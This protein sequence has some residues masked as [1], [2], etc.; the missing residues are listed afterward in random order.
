VHFG[1][2]QQECRLYENNTVV[3][4]TADPRA[5]TIK[6]ENAQVD[7]TVLARMKTEHPTQAYLIDELSKKLGIDMPEV[8]DSL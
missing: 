3:L 7:A 5:G 6:R 4:G 1:L 8:R 2:Q